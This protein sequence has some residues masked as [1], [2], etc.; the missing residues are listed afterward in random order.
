MTDAGMWAV[1]G[2]IEAVL[3]QRRPLTFLYDFRTIVLPSVSQASRPETPD[4]GPPQA[5]DS[6][7]AA[8]LTAPS[9]LLSVSQIRAGIAWLELPSATAPTHGTLLDEYMQVRRPHR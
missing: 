6:A 4:P 8:A 1:L 7:A 3:E 9:C 2:S 5:P